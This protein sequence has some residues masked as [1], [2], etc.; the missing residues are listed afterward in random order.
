MVYD[1]PGASADKA[2]EN[3]PAH[4]ARLDE[5]KQ[6]GVLLMAGPCV[7]EEGRPNGLAL[8]VFTT[9]E[10]A[11]EFIREDPFIVN[12]VVGK[13]RVEAWNEVLFPEGPA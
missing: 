8:G 7:N 6:R 13:W 5:F 2:L 11:E 3:Y 10:A 9:R 1:G 12:G 4:R